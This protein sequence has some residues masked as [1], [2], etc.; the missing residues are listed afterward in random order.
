MPAVVTGIYRDGKIEL[1]EPL[2]GIREGRVR[3]TLVEEVEPKSE[4]RYLQFG[5]YKADRDTPPE[6]FEEAEWHGEPEL[7]ASLAH[8]A[9][10]KGHLD[11]SRVPRRGHESRK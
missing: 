5:K 9:E 4:P 7:E 11:P 6:A 2:K 8:D 1:L 3:V 10:A